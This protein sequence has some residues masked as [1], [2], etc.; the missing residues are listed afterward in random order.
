M[1]ILYANLWEINGKPSTPR[2]A[3]GTSMLHLAECFD[4]ALTPRL[5]EVYTASLAELTPS[6]IIMAFSRATEECRFFPPPAI[7]REFSGHAADGDPVAREA[8]VQLL[9]LLDGMRGPHD[10]TLKPVLGKVLY[11]TEDDPRDE[12]GRCAPAPIRGESTPFPLSRRTQAALVR[13][14]WGDRTRGIAVIADHPALKRDEDS[15]DGQYRQ[16]QLRAADEILRRFTE[17]YRE[18]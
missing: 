11:G 8:K 7:L 17:A 9:Y 16:N 1:T 13:L 10:V 15:T 4:K 2:A 5:L 6:E 12:N 18:V 14:G 3:V